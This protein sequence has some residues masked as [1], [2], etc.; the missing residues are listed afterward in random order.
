[1]DLKIKNLE[2]HTKVKKCDTIELC[3]QLKRM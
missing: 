3:I 1:M 2:Q